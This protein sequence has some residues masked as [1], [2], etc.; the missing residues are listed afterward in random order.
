MA[1]RPG[2]AIDESTP[3][4]QGAAV[5]HV[6][7]GDGRVIRTEGDKTVVLLTDVGYKTISA[8]LAV[9]RRLLELLDE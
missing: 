1:E 9:E 6:E 5:R 2:N 4:P 8:S 7:W 3:F